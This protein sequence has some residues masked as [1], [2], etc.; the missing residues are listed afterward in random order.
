MRD[1]LIP[2]MLAGM[3]FLSSKEKIILF[4]KLDNGMDLALLSI[5]DISLL[6]GRRIR[7]RSWNG[8]EVRRQAEQASRLL[9]AFDIKGV[10]FNDVAYPALVREI[11]D[12]PFMLF[13]RGCLAAIENPC[14][15]IVGTRRPS[16]DGAKAAFDFAR[17]A[18]DDGLTVVSGLAFGIDSSAHKGAVAVA[19]KSVGVLPCG[20]DAVYPYANRR[21]AVAMLE[22]GGCL[23]SEY[24]PGVPP[25]KF[26]FPQ[27]N[28]LIAALS[29]TTLVVEAPPKSGAL[30]TADFALEQGRDVYLHRVACSVS[31]ERCGVEVYRRDG[32]PV[33]SSYAEFVQCRAAAPGTV[34]CKTDKQ[35][36]F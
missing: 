33:V 13:Y 32:A 21:L 17:A 6:L 8:S 31:P 22:H 34:Y 1:E 19:G 5:D 12:P 10:L 27:R 23:L 36:Y 3:H 26:R 20:V 35:L 14:V 15:S 11:F 7:S 4:G 24:L 30:I 18:A 25:L 28:R 16:A 2:L 9:D 29:P